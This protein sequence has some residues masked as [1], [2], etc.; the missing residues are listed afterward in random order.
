MKLSLCVA[1][2]K[3]I[4]SKAEIVRNGMH[5]EQGFNP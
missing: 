5:K 4:G 3:L 1:L 2:P